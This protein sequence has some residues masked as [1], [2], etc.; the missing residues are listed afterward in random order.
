MRTLDHLGRPTYEQLE[1]DC[2]ALRTEVEALKQKNATLRKVLEALH[3]K[4]SET[5]NV[6]FEQDGKPIDIVTDLGEA[7]QESDL[8]SQ[9][10][11]A[12]KDQ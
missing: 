7:Y 9:V 6:F 11:Q 5:C 8:C 2:K 4:T 1:E 10:Y 3:K 12:L